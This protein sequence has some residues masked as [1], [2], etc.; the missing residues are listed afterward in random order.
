MGGCGMRRVVGVWYG[1]DLKKVEFAFAASEFLQSFR[2]GTLL[3]V[4]R[5]A[6][7]LH[8][9]RSCLWVECLPCLPLGLN[10]AEAVGRSRGFGGWRDLLLFLAGRAC[11]RHGGRVGMVALAIRT[12]RLVC[13][14]GFDQTLQ[15]G[16]AFV[17]K[18]FVPCPE[19]G[20]LRAGFMG[21]RSWLM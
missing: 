2:E 10:L 14:P 19:H 6:V 5:G 13:E 1:L 11:F 12:L 4:D 9:F 7:W 3:R 8:D 21:L 15:C 17:A 16:L 20:F 18:R